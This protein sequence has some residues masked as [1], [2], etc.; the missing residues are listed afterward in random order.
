[1]GINLKNPYLTEIF[2]FG[3]WEATTPAVDGGR[4]RVRAEALGEVEDGGCGGLVAAQVFLLENEWQHWW[5]NRK[6]RSLRKMNG[7]RRSGF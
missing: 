2:R 6:K 3:S 7:R 4:R 5:Q 1:T